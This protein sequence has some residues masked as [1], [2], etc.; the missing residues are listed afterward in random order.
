MSN[1]SYRNCNILFNR[2]KIIFI[3]VTDKEQHK[4]RDVVVDEDDDVESISKSRR[5]KKKSSVVQISRR[6]KIYI[7]NTTDIMR[8]SLFRLL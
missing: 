3:N 2:S 7:T 6:R 4:I 8:L 5:H 1:C